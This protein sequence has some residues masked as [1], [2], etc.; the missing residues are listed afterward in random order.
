MA[1]LLEVSVLCSTMEETARSQQEGLPPTNTG[2]NTAAQGT[3]EKDLNEMQLWP[4]VLGLAGCVQQPSFIIQWAAQ[5]KEGKILT[6]ATSKS[7]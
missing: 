2:F 7:A 4:Q 1:S 3:E 6:S 5:G